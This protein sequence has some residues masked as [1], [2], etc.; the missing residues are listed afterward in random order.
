MVYGPMAMGGIETLILRLLPILAD[1]RHRV[2]LLCQPGPLVTELADESIVHFFSD[3]DD[4]RRIALAAVGGEDD[5]AFISF[6]PTSCAL[7]AWLRPSAPGS[8]HISGAYHPHAWF[9]EDDPLRLA[10]NR[11]LLATVADRDIFFINEESRSAHASWARRDFGGSAIIPLAVAVHDPREPAPSAILRVVSVGRLTGFK[12]YNRHAARIATEMAAA[13]RPVEWDIYGTG[14][15]EAAIR[16]E[17]ERLG[18]QAL[19][20]LKG[21]LP[22]RE[23]PTIGERYDVFVGMGTAALEAATLGL[24]TIV[25]AV[26]SDDRCYGFVQDLP[27]GNVGERLDRPPP[28][29]VR[30]LLEEVAKADAAGR[31]AMG[32]GSRAAGARY[33]MHAYA[34]ALLDVARDAGR[35]GSL[36]QRIATVIYREATVGRARRAIHGLKRRLGR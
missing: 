29:T 8:R 23:F 32:L 34:D 13:G 17:I 24:P 26:N 22:Y 15:L 4:A 5:V 9:L 25:P 33:S 6:D 12:E 28:H 19:V 1:A 27:H 14:E 21:E 7:A 11:L 18:A 10:I 3:W 35:D 30:E 16:R 2:T 31:R 20:R 36:R